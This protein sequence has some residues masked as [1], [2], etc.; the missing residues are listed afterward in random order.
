ML[1]NQT[2]LTSNQKLL[3]RCGGWVCKDPS[4][5][6]QQVSLVTPFLVFVSFVIMT[7]T[8]VLLFPG[9]VIGWMIISWSCPLL[10]PLLSIFKC[11]PLPC[12][13][14]SHYVFV[15]VVALCLLLFYYRCSCVAPC[16]SFCPLVVTFV[17]C[18]FFLSKNMYLVCWSC[19]VSSFTVPICKRM[20][21]CLRSCQH[22]HVRSYPVHLGQEHTVLQALYQRDRW[23]LDAP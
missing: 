1:D 6:G 22:K 15:G 18:F 12:S 2:S 16:F 8:H 23:N 3:V 10:K 4:L 17:S 20:R 5:P 11:L 19:N 21:Y 14:V 9:L 7:L 13:P